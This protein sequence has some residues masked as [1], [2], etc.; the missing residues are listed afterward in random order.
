M[1]KILILIISLFF[2]TS[3]YASGQ[4]SGNIGVH[5]IIGNGC[6]ITGEQELTFGNL[7]F[8]EHPNIN[9]LID[10]TTT[11]KP[12]NIISVNCTKG[13]SFHLKVNN[14]LQPE[15]PQRRMK[16]EKNEF[17]KY[18]LYKD[19]A[20]SLLWNSDEIISK[21][22]T[23]QNMPL[24]IYGRVPKQPV[25]SAGKYLDILTITVSW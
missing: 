12:V 20:Y 25:P 9:N 21:K 19:A 8:G 18:D 24:V 10:T 13:V 5:M 11:S 1:N 6:E 16:G 22:G 7:D 23:G 2:S 3:L 4:I 17:I 15:G 14:G